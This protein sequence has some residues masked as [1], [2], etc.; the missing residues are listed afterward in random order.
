MQQAEAQIDWL[1]RMHAAGIYSDTFAYPHLK[2]LSFEF[3]L[4]LE[5]G[6]GVHTK[7]EI[8]PVQYAV[9][10][11]A[12]ARPQITDFTPGTTRCHRALC[13]LGQPY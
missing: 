2:N 1:G 6:T 10:A 4:P 3:E 5:P 12:K 11:P 9:A 8:M 13:I 7:N